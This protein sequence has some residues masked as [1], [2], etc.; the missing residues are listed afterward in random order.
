MVSCI[1]AVANSV[2]F[3]YVKRELFRFAVNSCS[4]SVSFFI[5]FDDFQYNNVFGIV[6]VDIRSR[7]RR[8][9]RLARS[10]EDSDR[11]T[12]P[13]NKP[14]EIF[15]PKKRIYESTDYETLFILKKKK[16][17]RRLLCSNAS[18][19]N[20]L[21]IHTIFYHPKIFSTTKA[22]CRRSQRDNG[23]HQHRTD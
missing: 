20:P 13:S 1:R 2:Y 17:I 6:K 11:D 7:L 12:T 21:T 19:I 3:H 14:H 16:T 9:F 8:I 5:L 10:K 18:A 15:L 4:I 22:R 23:R